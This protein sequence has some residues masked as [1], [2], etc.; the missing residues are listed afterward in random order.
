MPIP[1]SPPNV[2]PL[3]FTHSP[4]IL[5]SI[6]SKIK[7]VFFCRCFFH[8]PYLNDFAKQPFE[9]FSNPLAAFFEN[10]NIADFILSGF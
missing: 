5:A 7:I 6:G 2:V 10:Q 1:S 3:A 4:S 8:K 9:D